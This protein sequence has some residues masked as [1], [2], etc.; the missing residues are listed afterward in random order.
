[1]C[2]MLYVWDNER[3]IRQLAVVQICA[4]LRKGHQVQNLRAAVDY[5]GKER[6]WIVMARIRKNIAAGVADRWQTLGIAF[7]GFS[8]AEQMAD[9]VV[10][11]NGARQAIV[12]G[13]DLPRG[14]D[15]KSTRLNSS[16]VKISYAV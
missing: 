3:K 4:E 8:G 16:H 11:R 7:P 5:I 13:D 9:H 2:V 14:Q 15:R 12:I 10:G 6:E 1:M